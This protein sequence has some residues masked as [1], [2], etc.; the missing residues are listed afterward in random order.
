MGHLHLHS[1][2]RT[3]GQRSVA[4]RTIKYKS[5]IQKEK[6]SIKWKVRFVTSRSLDIVNSG[7]AAKEDTFHKCVR[8]SQDAMM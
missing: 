2:P 6:K 7:K 4:R 8:V 5:E 3:A 1:E